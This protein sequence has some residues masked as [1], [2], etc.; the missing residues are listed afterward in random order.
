[1]G[2]IWLFHYAAPLLQLC[3]HFHLLSFLG[4][5]RSAHSNAYLYGFFKNK[6]IVLFDTLIKG[7][8][9]A[10]SKDEKNKE[11]SEKNVDLTADEKTKLE[12]KEN[13]KKERGCSTDEIVAVLGHELGHWKYSHTIKGLIIVEVQ[14]M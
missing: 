13:A 14:Y 11:T 10:D 9:P 1:M 5:K 7:Y 12:E 6:R 8:K 2:C 4:S 3:L